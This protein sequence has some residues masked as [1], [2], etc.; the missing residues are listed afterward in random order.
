MTERIVYIQIFELLPKSKEK[1]V[2]YRT[3]NNQYLCREC[4]KNV[5]HRK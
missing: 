5:M 1:G 3:Y 4:A 2:N